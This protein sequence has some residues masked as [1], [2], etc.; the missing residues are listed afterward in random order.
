MPLDGRRMGLDYGRLRGHVES[1]GVG[2]IAS[3]FEEN[4]LVV[5]EEARVGLHVY[6]ITLTIAP[7]SPEIDDIPSLLGRD[8]PDQWRM[9]YNPPKGTL[10]FTV[11]S[12]DYVL[13]V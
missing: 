5:F 8:I 3:N 10:T 1:T 2:G 11:A 7:P 13:P 9:N 12:S 6:T 4:A